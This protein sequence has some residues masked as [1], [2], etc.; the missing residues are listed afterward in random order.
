MTECSR[1]GAGNY[2]HL[3]ADMYLIKFSRKSFFIF[4]TSVWSK[5]WS[6]EFNSHKIEQLGEKNAILLSSARRW[7][8]NIIIRDL[9]LRKKMEVLDG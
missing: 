6:E 1:S 9:V 8:H 2:E 5:E 3:V 4:H 7:A